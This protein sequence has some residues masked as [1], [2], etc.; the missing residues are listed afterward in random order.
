MGA[1]AL[2]VRL[3][4]AQLLQ[5]LQV[6]AGGGGVA[7]VDGAV[8]GGVDAAALAHQHQGAGFFVAEGFAGQAAQGQIELEGAEDDGLRVARRRT[9]RTGL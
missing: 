9:G 3:Q 6:G 1:L 2:A 8:G 4:Q 7:A 5:A